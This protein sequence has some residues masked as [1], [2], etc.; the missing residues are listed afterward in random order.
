[1]DARLEQATCNHH[2]DAPGATGDERALSPQIEKFC[3]RCELVGYHLP[4]FSLV[5]RDD[6]DASGV[7]FSC[8]NAMT[9]ECTPSK[10][11]P[12]P[13]DR[14]RDRLMRRRA[15]A[16]RYDKLAVRYEATVLVAVLNEWL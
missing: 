9:L 12:V 16:A 15:V 4:P 3:M 1:M 5:V 2:S 7:R 6:A 10:R 13:T 11:I 14:V 8:L